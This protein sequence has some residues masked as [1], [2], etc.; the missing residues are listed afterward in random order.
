MYCVREDGERRRE[1]GREEGMKGGERERER[2]RERIVLNLIKSLF[3]ER[4][5]QKETIVRQPNGNEICRRHTR[6]S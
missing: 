2:E 4:S 6:T 1:R 5:P 3:S